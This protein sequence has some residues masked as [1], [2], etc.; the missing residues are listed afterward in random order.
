MIISDIDVLYITVGAPRPSY[1]GLC[2]RYLH[3]PFAYTVVGSVPKCVDGNIHMWN[4]SGLPTWAG[5]CAAVPLKQKGALIKACFSKST[6]L[7][8]LIKRCGRFL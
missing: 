2:D 5:V 4:L 8:E 6:D 3:R 7:V 1:C